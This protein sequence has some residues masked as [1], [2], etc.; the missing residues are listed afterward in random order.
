MLNVKIL[1]KKEHVKWIGQF[2]SMNEF[3]LNLINKSIHYWSYQQK[4]KFYTQF[5]EIIDLPKVVF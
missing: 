2:Q 4:C 1:Q 3:F 5:T